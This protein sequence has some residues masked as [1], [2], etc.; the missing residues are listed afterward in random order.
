ML[1]GKDEENNY[2]NKPNRMSESVIMVIQ[3]P[4]HSDGFRYFKYSNLEY[5]MRTFISFV[6][7][8]QLSP[9]LNR[10]FWDYNKK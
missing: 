6:P 9:H 10:R 8:L 7:V 5:V 1:E 4:F 2:R 3:I